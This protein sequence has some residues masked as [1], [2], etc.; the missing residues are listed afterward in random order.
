MSET[1]GNNGVNTPGVDPNVAQAQP[2]VTGQPNAQASSDPAK[3]AAQEAM[4]KFKVKVE[5]QELE[6]DEKELLRGYS[7]QKAANKSLQEGKAARK[8]AEE[9]I[10][11]MKD[12]GKLFDAIKKLGHDPRTL[13]EK[14][15]WAQLQDEQ[16]DPRDK[17]LRDTK[18]KLKQIEDMERMQREAVEKK[19]NEALKA[20]YAEDF[21]SQFVSALQE[22]NLPPTKPM[23]AEM[24][25]YV[26]RA[27]QIGFKMTPQE[28][29]QLVKEDLQKAHMALIGDSDGDTLI[30]LLG[31]DV[32]NKVRKWDTSRVRTP[33]QNLKTPEQQGEPSQRTRSNGK[34]MTPKEW[35]DFNRKK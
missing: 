30:R 11:M 20:K 22:T 1:N 24:A 6:V 23:V 13:A 21:S 2:G 31:E 14:F 17:E 28:A 7:H 10:S 15:L 18:A 12:E 3:E 26:A 33:E 5:G 25:K 27:A 9:F 29:A 16:M 35:R 32:A 8:Q 4:R 34:R 19:R